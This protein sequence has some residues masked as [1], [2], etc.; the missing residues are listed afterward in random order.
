MATAIYNC[1]DKGVK[2]DA[3]AKGIVKMFDNRRGKLTYAEYWDDKNMKNHEKHYNEI[4][5]QLAAYHATVGNL[6]KSGLLS[7]PK[8]SGK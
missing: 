4:W 8:G 3:L 5:Q 2:I 6:T 1:F 7:K